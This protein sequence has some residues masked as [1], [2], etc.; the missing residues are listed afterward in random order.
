M[1]WEAWRPQAD[2]C[3]LAL[4]NLEYYYFI[5]FKP[6][7]SRNGSRVF[8]CCF[9]HDAALASHLHLLRRIKMT[10][11]HESSSILQREYNEQKEG[12]WRSRSLSSPRLARVWM[13]VLMLWQR[14]LLP[15]V[16]SQRHW[17][18]KQRRISLLL[19]SSPLLHPST[20]VYNLLSADIGRMHARSQ[21]HGHARPVVVNK[22]VGVFTFGA[23]HTK[24]A[25]R[26]F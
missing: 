2:T 20:T 3:S 22:I 24:I 10:I 25:G 8:C 12:R 9:F 17:R 16:G 21:R 15:P 14:Y 19:L 5:F 13:I 18:C 26:E 4:K 6:H 23:T 11:S 7:K 1:P